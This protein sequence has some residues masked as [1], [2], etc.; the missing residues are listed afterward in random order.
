MHVCAWVWLYSPVIEYTEYQSTKI[1]YDESSRFPHSHF[2]SVVL[3]CL[4]RI[5]L[6]VSSSYQVAL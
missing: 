1:L 2:M 5:L 6:L 4:A 3:S